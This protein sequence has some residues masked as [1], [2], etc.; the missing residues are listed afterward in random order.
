MLEYGY[1]YKPSI[2]APH[3]FRRVIRR[4]EALNAYIKGKII[5]SGGKALK[6]PY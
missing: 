4:W 5:I 1:G 3:G 2:G 6:G